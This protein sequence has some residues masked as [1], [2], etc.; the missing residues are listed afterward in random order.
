MVA[1][2]TFGV[3]F[4]SHKCKSMKC[5]VG[6][7]CGHRERQVEVEKKERRVLTYVT[8]AMCTCVASGRA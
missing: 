6:G 8:E 4:M 3:W 2:G 5:L 1:R 7:Y